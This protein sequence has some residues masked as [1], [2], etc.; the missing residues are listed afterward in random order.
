MH[1][2]YAQHLFRDFIHLFCST[3]HQVD[4]YPYI[5]SNTAHIYVRKSIESNI[6][7][8]TFFF[9]CSTARDLCVYICSLVIP[10]CCQIF[11]HATPH[12]VSMLISKTQFFCVR[13][14]HSFQE[15]N[16]D[17]SHLVYEANEKKNTTIPYNNNEKIRN[18][19][20]RARMT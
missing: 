4:E 5:V 14:L 2:P 19:S 6:R 3:I 20:R 10:L 12:K 17:L 11:C 9:C 16:A 7:R 1:K 8:H 15:H 13:Q 18:S